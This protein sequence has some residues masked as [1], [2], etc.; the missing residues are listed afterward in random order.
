VFR[1]KFSPCTIVLGK[2]PS[3]LQAPLRLRLM[4]PSTKVVEK[5]ELCR[6]STLK[7]KRNDLHNAL[8]CVSEFLVLK[9]VINTDLE[10]RLCELLSTQQLITKN[11]LN[12]G[13][14]IRFD[15]HVEFI[16]LVSQ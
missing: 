2:Y 15:A 9:Y 13:K 3:S 14:D 16:F 5:L 1:L 6:S 8:D 4:A 12:K 11:S 7:R 10:G